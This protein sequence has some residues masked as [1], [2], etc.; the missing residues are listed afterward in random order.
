MRLILARHGETPWNREGRYQGHSQTGLNFHGRRQAENLAR[1][2][3]AFPV[4]ALYASPL[5]RAMQTAETVAKA[6][7]IP[8]VSLDGLMEMH[9]GDLDGL[10]GDEMRRDHP[11]ILVQWDKDPSII[12]IPGGESLPQVQARMLASVDR[13]RNDNPDGLVVAVSHGLAIETAV[14]RVL[15]LPLSQLRRVRVDLGSLTVLEH[16]G[17]RWRLRSFNETLHQR[18]G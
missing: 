12:Q 3:R 17:D 9:L 2:L 10:T 13:I 8:I 16:N 14:L 4:T 6:L 11:E 7:S 15:G 18:G 5:L 1:A